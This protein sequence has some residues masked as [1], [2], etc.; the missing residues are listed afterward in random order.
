MGRKIFELVVGMTLLSV[1]LGVSFKSLYDR[2]LKTSYGFEILKHYHSEPF[3]DEDV[4]HFKGESM[5][6]MTPWYQMAYSGVRQ[7]SICP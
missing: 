2:E 1:V 7:A 3:G 6:F 5:L 4:K